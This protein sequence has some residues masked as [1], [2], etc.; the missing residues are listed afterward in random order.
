KVFRVRLTQQE[1]D[2]LER[3]AQELGISSAELMRDYIK[4][5]A[6]LP[7]SGASNPSHVKFAF[8]LF[9]VSSITSGI[10]SIWAKLKWQRFLQSLPQERTWRHFVQTHLARVTL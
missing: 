10:P 3:N 4:S 2:K 5:L 1:W 9:T 8:R 6:N 7:A